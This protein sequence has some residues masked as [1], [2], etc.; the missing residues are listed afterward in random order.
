MTLC[1]RGE[2][3]HVSFH[4]WLE[5]HRLRVHVSHRSE[6]LGSWT[7]LVRNPLMSKASKR[8]ER[9][10]GERKR[11]ERRERQRRERRERRREKKEREES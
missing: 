9:E 1:D 7:V 4:H 2:T 3:P 10:R 11:R 8:E 5:R 6:A